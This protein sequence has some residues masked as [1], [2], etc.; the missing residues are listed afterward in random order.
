MVFKM[1][2]IKYEP[3]KALFEV[4]LTRTENRSQQWGFDLTELSGSVL[5]QQL[6]EPQVVSSNPVWGTTSVFTR[7]SLL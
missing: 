4:T 6:C 3:I 1:L 2:C 7:F 5:K